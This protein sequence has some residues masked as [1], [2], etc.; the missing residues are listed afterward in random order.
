MPGILFEM[1]EKVGGGESKIVKGGENFNFCLLD[2]CKNFK[3]GCWNISPQNQ[4]Q[5]I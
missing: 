1:L 4:Q 5:E 2:F 3:S